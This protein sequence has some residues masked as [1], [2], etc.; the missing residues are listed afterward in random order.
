MGS[1]HGWKAD[2][3]SLFWSQFFLFFFLLTI[4]GL[5]SLPNFSLPKQSWIPSSK[6]SLLQHNFWSVFFFFRL[7][8]AVIIFPFDVSVI[9]SSAN[10]S[11]IY[12]LS[13]LLKH[14]TSMHNSPAPVIQIK[15][16][17]ILLSIIIPIRKL[18]ETNIL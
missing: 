15:S 12:H 6:P 10:K 4:M 18:K 11:I 8:Q 17:Q 14:S 2:H 1:E 5:N 9:F 13:F 7:T 16:P 3:V